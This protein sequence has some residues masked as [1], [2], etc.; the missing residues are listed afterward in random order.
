MIEGMVTKLNVTTETLQMWDMTFAQYVVSQGTM[1]SI[2]ML[3]C[4]N[5]LTLYALLD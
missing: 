2:V 1:N 3:Q 5:Y 4:T